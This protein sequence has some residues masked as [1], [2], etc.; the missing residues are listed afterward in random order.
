MR[1]LIIGAGEAALKLLATISDSTYQVVAFVDDDPDKIG[2]TISG[3]PVLGPIDQLAKIARETETKEIMIAIPSA[4]SSLIRRVVE[5]AGRNHLKSKIIPRTIDIVR[6]LVRFEQ[7][8]DIEPADLLGR[9]VVRHDLDST[10]EILKDKT[11]M[12]T[13]AAGSIGSGLAWQIA[14]LGPKKIICFDFNESAMFAL[15]NNLSQYGA[16]VKYVIGNIVDKERVDQVIKQHRPDVIFHAAAYKHV[17]LMEKNIVEAVKNNVLGTKTVALS[18]ISNEVSDFILISSDKAINPKS[19]MGATKRI[20]EK[21]MYVLAKMAKTRFSGVRF[22]NVLVSNGSV[23]PVFEEQIRSGGPVTITN[24]EMKRYFMTIEE[25]V[26]LVIQSWAL[27]KNGEIF[28]LDMGEPIKIIDLANNLIRAYGFV[29][30][31][32]IKVK[33]IGGRPGE[34]LFEEIS[35]DQ[36]KVSRTE[37][38]K[39]FIVKKEEDFDPDEFLNIVKKLEKAKEDSE[40]KELIKKAVPNYDF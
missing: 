29:P 7:V 10:R 12:I 25:A 26:Q 20:V 33:I 5:I 3:L 23:I 28:V 16:N 35:T 1:V 14:I 13:G 31:S 4:Q 17:P 18:A 6:G 11:I 32:D 37:H 24:P 8:R 15:E 30:G 22:G 34:K 40:L 2:T 39:I 19:I 36:S 38:S 27:G 21:M 9:P